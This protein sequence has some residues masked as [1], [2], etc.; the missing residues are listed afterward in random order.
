MGTPVIPYLQ[1]S[2]QRQRRYITWLRLQTITQQSPG[3]RTFSRTPGP[4]FPIPA[5][6]HDCSPRSRLIPQQQQARP[7]AEKAQSKTSS[8][9]QLLI[10]LVR[11]TECAILVKDVKNRRDGRKSAVTATFSLPRFL[12]FLY[13]FSCFDIRINHLGQQFNL[14]WK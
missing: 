1:L 12:G 5:S 6:Q 3:G 7:P 4:T 14:H 2:K 8:K 13:C 9:G 11:M 10:Y